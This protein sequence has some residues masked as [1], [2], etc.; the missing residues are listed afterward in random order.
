[1][2]LVLRQ[3]GEGGYRPKNLTLS[4]GSEEAVCPSLLREKAKRS[5]FAPKRRESYGRSNLTSKGGVLGR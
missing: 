3:G 5:L 1:L 2:S 4:E